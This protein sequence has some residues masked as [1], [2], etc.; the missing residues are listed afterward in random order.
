MLFECSV[1]GNFSFS[2][3]TMFLSPA[4]HLNIL[5]YP[6]IRH[7]D[8]LILTGCS[9]SMNYLLKATYI[10]KKMKCFMK[11]YFKNVKIKWR[12]N[13][14]WTVTSKCVSMNSTTKERDKMK[15]SESH[16][17]YFLVSCKIDIKLLILSL[18]KKIVAPVP[19]AISKRGGQHLAYKRF[20]RSFGNCC[21]SV[22]GYSK[23]L[24]CYVQATH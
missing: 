5:Q 7:K 23:Q 18:L 10:K 14:K 16:L 19:L 4:T 3:T 20:S 6:I 13:I 24:F 21:G 9:M 1:L 11:W 15:S 2:L 17:R 22:H 12:I 8:K